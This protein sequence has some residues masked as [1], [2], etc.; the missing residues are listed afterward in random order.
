MKKMIESVPW[1]SLYVTLLDCPLPPIPAVLKRGSI[2][3]RERGDVKENGAGV[4]GSCWD[5][6]G[7]T[8]SGWEDGTELTRSGW[9]G[10]GL[11][12]SG[13]DGTEPRMRF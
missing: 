5:G 3:P 9:D 13:W 8:C 7:L 4:I 12:C 1:I 11:T 2:S 6:A 10:T